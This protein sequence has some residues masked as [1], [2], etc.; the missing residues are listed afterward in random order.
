MKDSRSLA[1]R[2]YSGCLSATPDD[3]LNW[4]SRYPGT[5][6]SIV[7]FTHALEGILWLNPSN[8]IRSVTLLG[9]LFASVGFAGSAKV[10]LEA[11]YSI[12]NNADVRKLNVVILLTNISAENIVLPTS[13]LGPVTDFDTARRIQTLFFG[14]MPQVLADGRKV[15]APV[16]LFLPVELAA[17]E[18]AVIM[19]S[20]VITEGTTTDKVLIR[21]LVD[22]ETGRK[23]KFLSV[24]EE[25]LASR[26]PL[27]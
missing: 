24:D 2:P 6:D 4:L 16:S 22:E 10:K 25:V 5:Y 7:I 23:Y 26:K 18:S 21:Y 13:N 1:R 3:F 27:F 14:H 17:G 20:I 19:K 12:T 8:M 11:G 15:V 9:L